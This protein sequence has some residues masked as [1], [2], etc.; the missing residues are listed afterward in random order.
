MNT[1]FIYENALNN[2]LLNSFFYHNM[3]NILLL[4]LVQRENIIKRRIYENNAHF[5]PLI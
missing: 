2:K 3:I 4:P 5:F 1:V